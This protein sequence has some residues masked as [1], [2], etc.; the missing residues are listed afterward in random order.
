MNSGSSRRRQEEI[1]DP[2]IRSPLLR[3]RHRAG[4]MVIYLMTLFPCSQ[5]S[6]STLQSW[7]FSTLYAL[8]YVANPVDVSDFA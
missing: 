8:K 7:H 6:H 3:R 4:D 5:L 2:T 1:A